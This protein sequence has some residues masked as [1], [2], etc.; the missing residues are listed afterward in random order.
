MDYFSRKTLLKYLMNMIDFNKRDIG[1][2]INDTRQKYTDDY[3]KLLRVFK[4]ERKNCMFFATLNY[5]SM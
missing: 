5:I 2:F 4:I 3:S 1:I